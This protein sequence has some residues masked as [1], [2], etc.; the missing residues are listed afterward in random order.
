MPG[1]LIYFLRE[2]VIAECDDNLFR[3]PAERVRQFAGHWYIVRTLGTKRPKSWQQSWP[4]S[5]ARYRVLAD[6]GL[7]TARAERGPRRGLRRPALVL[8]AHR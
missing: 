6:H 2:F 7:V 8:P 5:T 4:A 1:A 3:L